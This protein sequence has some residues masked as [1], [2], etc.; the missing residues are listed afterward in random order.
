MDRFVTL[1]GSD[2]S[3][4]PPKSA[5][6]VATG[7]QVSS[8]QSSVVVW[9]SPRFHHRRLEKW[10]RGLVAHAVVKQ[11]YCLVYKVHR[12]PIKSGR[13]ER[14]FRSMS[15]AG[16]APN[17]TPRV[18]QTASQDTAWAGGGVRDTMNCRRYSVLTLTLASFSLHL[19]ASG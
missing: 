19:I 18:G 13:S 7:E 14:G 1:S 15:E 16:V 6:A 11:T 9:T 10:V 3:F 8:N 5:D 4:L 12:I 2:S 17:P